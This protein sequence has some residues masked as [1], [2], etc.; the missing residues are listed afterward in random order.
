MLWKARKR[1]DD[2]IGNVA[3]I[4]E[5]INV[6]KINPILIS[7]TSIRHSFHFKTKTLY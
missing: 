1:T 3:I 6:A 4:F 2:T 5:K 7:A